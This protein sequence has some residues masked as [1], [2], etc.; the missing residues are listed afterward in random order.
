MSDIVRRH[1]LTGA[2]VA[3][4]GANSRCPLNLARHPWRARIGARRSWPSMAP[5]RAHDVGNGCS[6]PHPQL[7]TVSGNVPQ[8]SV[9]AT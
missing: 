9:G 1:V 8:P 6:H 7:P 3:G 4:A 2:V 5:R